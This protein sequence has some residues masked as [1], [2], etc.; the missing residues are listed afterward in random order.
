M[1][2]AELIEALWDMADSEP[3]KRITV[4]LEGRQVRVDDASW[5]FPIDDFSRWR[6]MEGLDDIG[7]TLRHEDTITAYE[8]NRPAFKPAVA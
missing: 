5:Q 8:E 2:K 3:E 4:D 1:N 7:L 6:L